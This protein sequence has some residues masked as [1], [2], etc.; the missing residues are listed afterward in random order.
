MARPFDGHG[1]PA[2]MLGAGGVLAPWL[3][4]AALS[5]E[6][7]QFIGILIVH[8]ADFLLAEGAGAP[9]TRP[10]ARPTTAAKTPATA[11]PTITATAIAAAALTTRLFLALLSATSFTILCQGYASLL[12]I[13]RYRC[14]GLRR[15]L[16]GGTV[17]ARIEHNHIAGHDLSPVIPGA[18]RILPRAGLEP[19]LYVDP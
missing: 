10:A 8:F 12:F 9:A 7:A 17:T 14:I 5:Q 16:G 1:Q 18:L 4:L 19:A 3:D 15:P 11:A 2:L 13:S 6:A